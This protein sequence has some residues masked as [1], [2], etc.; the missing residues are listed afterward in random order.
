[1]KNKVWII[2]IAVLII[3]SGGVSGYFT[4]R[5]V[6]HFMD[7]MEQPVEKPDVQ[8]GT[9]SMYEKMGISSDELGAYSTPEEA[10]MNINKP[11][12]MENVGFTSEEITAMF[13]IS[14]NDLKAFYAESAVFNIQPDNSLYI[15]V[16]LDGEALKGV[17]YLPDMA[18]S[19]ITKTKFTLHTT[20]E[21]VQD[22]KLM[23]K[24]NDIYT[25]EVHVMNFVNLFNLGSEVR[26][27]FS[28]YIGKTVSL[29]ISVLKDLKSFAVS[30]GLVF[31]DATFQSGGAGGN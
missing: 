31:I 6:N 11:I 9:F 4:A 25:G 16:Y 19:V 22:G 12:K 3:L 14:K 20:V 23:V 29:D 27:V 21:G 18:L 2:I 7:E 5:A 15:D 17:T 30:D 26:G 10:I 13:N 8:K 28:E 1:M 24:I